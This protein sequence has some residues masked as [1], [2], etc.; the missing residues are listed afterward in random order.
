MSV[1][2]IEKID[3]ALKNIKMEFRDHA[4]MAVDIIRKKIMKEIK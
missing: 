2:I 1:K 4:G 3:E